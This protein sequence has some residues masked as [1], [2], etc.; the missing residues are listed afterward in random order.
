M[1]DG[2]TNGQAGIPL[3]PLSTGGHVMRTDS[4]KG[5]VESPSSPSAGLDSNGELK[6]SGKYMQRAWLEEEDP[7]A[8]TSDDGRQG[9]LRGEDLTDVMGTGLRGRDI[10]EK[11]QE[12]KS[13][14]WDAF[15]NMANSI[16]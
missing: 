9:L 15:F 14:L 11:I 3:R 13:G 1:L 12:V 4:V 6:G 16:M 2:A 5:G 7:L 8:N 10:G